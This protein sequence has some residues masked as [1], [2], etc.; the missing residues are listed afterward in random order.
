MSWEGLWHSLS[1]VVSLRLGRL[2]GGRLW[3]KG[4]EGAVLGVHR[5]PLVFRRVT[6]R[7][8]GSL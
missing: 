6:R 7:E 5:H 2:L 1:S 8:R 3:L 4:E